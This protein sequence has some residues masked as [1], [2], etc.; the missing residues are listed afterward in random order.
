MSETYELLFVRGGPVV[1]L[2]MVCSVAGLAVFIERSW[3]LRRKFIIPHEFSGRLMSLLGEAKFGEALA[4][5]NE[6]SSSLARIARAGLKNQGK[7]RE[8]IEGAM[9]GE[10]K[11]EMMRLERFIGWLGLIA[12]IAP[13]LGLLGTVSGMIRMFQQMSARGIGD[14]KFVAMGIWEALIAT[15]AGLIVAIP[16]FVAYRYLMAKVDNA[17]AALEEVSSELGERITEGGEGKVSG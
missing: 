12:T 9:E 7:T 10:G 15:A 13:L 16:S 17:V 11:R 8:K 3:A 6:N 4:A 1:Y 5:C 2:I 14:H